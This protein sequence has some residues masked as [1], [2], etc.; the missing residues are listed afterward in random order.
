MSTSAACIAYRTV[1]LKVHL[2]ASYVADLT[3][4]N[5]VS[6]RGS[7]VYSTGGAERYHITITP[8]ISM[9][10]LSLCT[11]QLHHG[12][13][14]STTSSEDWAKVAINAVSPAWKTIYTRFE[15]M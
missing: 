4:D 15:Y 5:L 13:T 1:R 2:G 9:A 8:T 10:D 3:V 11:T 14:Q 12:A 7:I 6:H